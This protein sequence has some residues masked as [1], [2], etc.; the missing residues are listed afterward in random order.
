MTVHNEEELRACFDELRAY[1]VAHAPA[2]GESW[3]RAGTAARSASRRR[4]KSLFWIAAA[5]CLLFAVGIAVRWSFDGRTSRS[6]PSTAATPSIHSWTSPTA[7]LL[8]VPG[9]EL[10]APQPILSSV[11]DGAAGTPVQ[12]KGGLE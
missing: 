8:R 4:A 7:S 10:L 12:T 2:F 6:R 11:L 5:A 3:G 9:R 1:D